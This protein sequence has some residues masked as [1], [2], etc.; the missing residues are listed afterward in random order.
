MSNDRTRKRN[1]YNDYMDDEEEEEYFIAQPQPQRPPMPQSPQARPR[2][3][4]RPNA[5]TRTGATKPLPN[6][7]N[8]SKGSKSSRQRS[9]WPWLLVGCAGGVVL[10]VLAA[11]IIVI[12]AV[13]NVTGSFPGLGNIGSASTYTQAQQQSVPMSGVTQL[14]VHNMIGD[15]T[16]KVDPNLTAPLV[17]TTK[18]VK[19]ASSDDANNEFKKIA[20]QVQPSGTTLQ[21]SATVPGGGTTFSVHNDSVTIVISLPS[22][23]NANPAMPLMLNTGAAAGNITS[24][25]NVSIDGLNGVLN[26]KD[27]FGSVTIQHSTLFDG[28]HVETGTGDVTFNGTLNTVVNISS[29]QSPLY[30]LQTETGSLYVT[31]PASMNVLLDGYTNTGTITSDYDLSHI[32]NPDGSFTGPLIYGATPVPT[33]LLQLHVSSGNIVIHKGV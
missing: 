13:R 1:E 3:Q 32:K 14:Q 31:L 26:I 9:A 29:K 25:G 15:V 6:R 27:D 28:S 10:L 5:N 17:A 33:A 4:A 20:I 2:P 18:N 23:V 19:T 11:A 21:V 22:S 7:S 16:I 12:I 8:R 30:I 24:V